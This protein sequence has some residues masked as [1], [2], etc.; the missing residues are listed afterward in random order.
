M[1]ALDDYIKSQQ[2]VAHSKLDQYIF[3]Q[4]QSNKEAA[5]READRLQEELTNR[6]FL[7]DQLYEATAVPSTEVN[8]P[9][10]QFNLARLDKM[11]DK[12]NYL[13]TRWPGKPKDSTIL[14][15]VTKEGE[16]FVG[17]EKDGSFFAVNKPGASWMD[18]PA[19][20]GELGAEFIGTVAGSV[21]PTMKGKIAMR[22]LTEGIA[23]ATGKTVD[24]VIDTLTL[25]QTETLSDIA[26]DISS[27]AVWNIVGGRLGDLGARIG[28][29]LKGRGFKLGIDATS[30]EKEAQADAV[31]AAINMEEQTGVHVPAPAIGGEVVTRA[32]NIAEVTGQSSVAKQRRIAV[33]KA[34]RAFDID[35]QNIVDTVKDTKLLDL[36]NL[37][38]GKATSKAMSAVG[39]NLGFK[40]KATSKE[41]GGKAIKSIW[42]EGGFAERSRST[43]KN[44]Y[45]N[46][47]DLAGTEG[48]TY[49]LT[50]VIKAAKETGTKYRL[51]AGT[52]SYKVIAG[53][54][55][56]RAFNTV[57]KARSEV[58]GANL[59]PE[60]ESL[61]KKLQQVDAIQ[62]N[63]PAEVTRALKQI[64]SSLIDLS[65]KTPLAPNKTVSQGEAT[66]LL[67]CS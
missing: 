50:N 15:L 55:A 62:K 1:T 6:Q 59:S 23:S 41:A 20:A 64:R 25:G 58:F 65:E 3:A 16:P 24:E 19:A 8:D 53:L 10:L 5:A 49:D 42:D 31:R 38:R 61:V 57:T 51:S 36:I 29:M 46:Y 54:D 4:Q 40:M 56:S 26:G 22:V 32:E 14:G 13:D 66:N 7:Q 11:Q 44:L 27:D 35:T 63:N 60:L 28:N 45:D 2:S 37:A 33:V 48:V 21:S 18:I 67:S 12:I 39:T 52:E 30:A 9:V 43:A 17:Y 34:L 47:F